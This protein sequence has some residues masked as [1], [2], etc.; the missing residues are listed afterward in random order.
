MDD[1]SN[2]GGFGG[3]SP[4]WMGGW[5]G[6]GMGGGQNPGW[7]GAGGGGQNPGWGGGGNMPQMPWSNPQQAAPFDLNQFLQP[8]AYQSMWNAQPFGQMGGQPS[9]QAPSAMDG[10]LPPGL[11]Q[12]GQALGGALGP[13]GNILGQA[14]SPLSSI[15]G[16]IFGMG[17]QGQ[18]GP[19][20]MGGQS[21]QG[22]GGGLF[23]GWGF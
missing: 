12:A 17:G 4:P 19:T 9:M 16:P 21:A 23:G 5:N 10:S 6:A 3:F 13:I 2:T 1:Y 14:L 15:L 7:G 11:G 22:R 18:A 8:Q 20:Q